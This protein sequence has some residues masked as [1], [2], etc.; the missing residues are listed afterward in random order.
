MLFFITYQCKVGMRG[1]KVIV[2]LKTTID[3]TL[4][5]QEAGYF[6]FEHIYSSKCFKL[7]NEVIKG[8]CALF[9][10]SPLH[11][12][13]WLISAITSDTFCRIWITMNEQNSQKITNRKSEIH[14][15]HRIPAKFLPK[16]IIK[17]LFSFCS[18]FYSVLN[19]RLNGPRVF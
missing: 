1:I 18:N 16:L 15:N 8:E 12:F 2:Q 19:W 13:I 6:I 9:Y 11:F 10:L 14:E 5:V 17:I 3:L 4:S 7:K